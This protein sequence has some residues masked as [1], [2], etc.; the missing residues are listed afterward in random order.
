ML[1][2]EETVSMAKVPVQ[3][4]DHLEEAHNQGIVHQGVLGMVIILMVE[5]DLS[6]VTPT[7][8]LKLGKYHTNL[9]GVLLHI[10]VDQ[11]SGGGPK[12]LEIELLKVEICHICQIRSEQSF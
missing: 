3:L 9:E 7:H 10:G 8:M 11:H 1:L 5:G 6:L 4:Q 12:L 2:R